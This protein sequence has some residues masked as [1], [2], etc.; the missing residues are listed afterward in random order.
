VASFALAKPRRSFLCASSMSS[1][2]IRV[3][4]RISRV[5]DVTTTHKVRYWI[6]RAVLRS[7]DL[8]LRLSE[9]RRFLITVSVSSPGRFPLTIL[10]PVSSSRVFQCKE[11]MFINN[12]CSDSLFEGQN[13][14]SKRG[15]CRERTCW[16]LAPV[17]ECVLI[18]ESSKQLR[19]RGFDEQRPAG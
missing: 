8:R 14:R 4:S 2:L 18:T 3:R 11:V 9:R 1:D 17:F 5:L 6:G 15:W 10:S 16:W 12:K 13:V 7:I 19:Q